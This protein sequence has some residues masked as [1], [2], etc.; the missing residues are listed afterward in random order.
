MDNDPREVDKLGIELQ[1]MGY[2]AEVQ[3]MVPKSQENLDASNVGG[4]GPQRQAADQSSSG[5]YTNP[6]V[7]YSLF[8]LSSGLYSTSREYL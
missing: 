8:I 2:E 7:S 6:N 3:N 4:L 5:L 1:A